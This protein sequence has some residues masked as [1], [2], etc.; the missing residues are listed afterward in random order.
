MPSNKKEKPVHVT[1]YRGSKDGYLFFLENGILWGFK[2]PILFLPFKDIASVSFTNVLQV[3]F[4]LAIEIQN[5]TDE[6]TEE[7]EFSMIDQQDYNSIGAYVTEHSLQD[8]SMAEQRKGKILLAENRAKKNADGEPNGDAGNDISELAKAQ[9]EVEQGM[10][11]DEDED[12][13]DYDPGSEG[14]SEGS[15]SSDDDNDDDDDDDPAGEGGEEDDD[16][17]MGEG[18]EEEEEEEEGDDE[19]APQAG[20]VPV[21]SGFASIGGSKLQ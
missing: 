15:G 21:R 5:G 7:L 17:E 10:Q 11:D 18:E 20:S 4:S 1:A 9:Q 14:D 13:E 12:E 2:K 3:T 16:D 19:P 6:D 8:R